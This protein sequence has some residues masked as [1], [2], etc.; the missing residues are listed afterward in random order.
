MNQLARVYYNVYETFE[1]YFVAL[2][3]YYSQIYLSS[4]GGDENVCS[5]YV[6]DKTLCPVATHYSQ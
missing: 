3:K 5:K 6:V 4:Y 1:L 2:I